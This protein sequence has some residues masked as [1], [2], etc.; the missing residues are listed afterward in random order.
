[1]KRN[2][3]ELILPGRKLKPSKLGLV[4]AQGYHAID[5]TL[6][7]PQ[8]RADIE[9][10]CHKI[11]K[12]EANKETVISKAIQFFSNKYNFFTNNIS[13]M[14]LLFGAS[15]TQLADV[16][17]PFT[18]CGFTRRYLNYIVGPPARLYNKYTETVYPLPIGGSVK[19]WMSTGKKCPVCNFELCLYSVGS[20]T[21]TFPCCVYCFNKVLDEQNQEDIDEADVLDEQKEQ[22]IKAIQGRANLTLDCPLSDTHPII[23][24]MTVHYDVTK[25]NAFILDPTSAGQKWKLISTSSPATIITFPKTV[26]KITILQKEIEDDDDDCKGCKFMKIDFKE[27]MDGKPKNY[28]CC[29]A[30]DEWIQKICSTFVVKEQDNGGRSSSGRGR[31][32][33]RGGGRGGRGGKGRG[34]GR[35]RQRR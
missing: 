18:R 25:R 22:E 35:G 32:K 8:V 12:G 26:E 11:A 29:F 10:Q 17:K 24:D 23:I 6:L 9:D 33:G 3:A 21:R 27:S 16:G 5:S 7:L 14:D 15:F 34:S 1:M 31:G 2:Y 4:L 20:P 19:Q 30:K 13:K 28:T